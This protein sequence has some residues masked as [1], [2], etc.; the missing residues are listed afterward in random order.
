MDVFP[1]AKVVPVPPFAIGSVDPYDNAMF[2]TDPDVVAVAVM[3][4]D[5]DAVTAVIPV[6]VPPN[7]SFHTP[8]P[9]I[10]V[11]VNVEAPP[12]GITAMMN[13]SLSFTDTTEL[14][15]FTKYNEA[16][17]FKVDASNRLMICPD[18]YEPLIMVPDFESIVGK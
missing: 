10:A 6:D 7:I 3:N 15:I 17:M 2:V 8:V 11:S 16:P 14:E 18:A 12:L 1:V 4:V 5:D 9:V 13:P